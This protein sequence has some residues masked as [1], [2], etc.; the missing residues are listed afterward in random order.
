[1]AADYLQTLE[2][3][4]ALYSK[5]Q[6]DYGS[7]ND[8]FA[9]VRATEGFGIPGW[10]GAVLRLNDKIVRI[11]SFCKKGRLANESV[12]DSIIDIAV[13]ASI[14]LTLYDQLHGEVGGPVS[15]QRIEEEKKEE[16]S[17]GRDDNGVAIG[18]DE[19]DGGGLGGHLQTGG[20]AHTL[21][22]LS[23]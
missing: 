6:E 17:D 1:M 18:A 7:D 5:K 11:K 3:M 12:R 9:N 14:A 16:A 23:D 10:L 4:R 13:Y 19:E 8:P 21:H 15:L 22:H 2:E 20:Q